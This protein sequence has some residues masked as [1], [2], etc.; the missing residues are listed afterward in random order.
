MQVNL[1]LETPHFEPVGIEPFTVDY[2]SQ[3][4]MPPSMDS[5]NFATDYS[6]VSQLGMPPSMDSP[7]ACQV[8]TRVPVRSPFDRC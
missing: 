2:A 6:Q 7:V 5:P 4:G 1:Q 8:F 3:L